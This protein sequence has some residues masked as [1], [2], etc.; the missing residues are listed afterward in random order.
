MA[1]DGTSDEVRY[2]D[3]DHDGLPDAVEHTRTIA[4]DTTG[5]GTGDVIETIR[6]TDAAIGIEGVAHHH[7][8]QR[9]LHVAAATPGRP[10]RSLTDRLRRARRVDGFAATRVKPRLVREGLERLSGCGERL[11][12]VRV[13][14]RDSNVVLSSPAPAPTWCATYSIGARLRRGAAT[15]VVVDTEQL[16]E[17]LLRA[18]SVHARGVPL[19]A[20]PPHLW[21]GDNELPGEDI[22]G[23]GPGGGPGGSRVIARGVVVPR[24][25]TAVGESGFVFRRGA[26]TTS[27]GLLAALAAAS[28]TKVDV[29][30]RAGRVTLEGRS[31]SRR[32]PGLR[33]TGQA[34]LRYT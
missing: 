33:I 25:E 18:E 8:A 4:F 9:R 29:V 11:E 27:N 17:A 7:D 23:V 16:A 20:R 31:A 2:L 12:R 10:R 24:P 13:S 19:I 32:G 34:L 26:I 5:D 1:A 15:A 6:E 14:M 28:I 3:L 22:A 30:E 21:I